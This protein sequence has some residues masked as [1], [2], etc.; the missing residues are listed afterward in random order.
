MEDWHAALEG[1]VAYF[2]S[3]KPRDNELVRVPRFSS[4]PF[5]VAP[6]TTY[7]ELVLPYWLLVVL[8]AFFAAL[9]I[10]PRFSLRNLI[11]AMSLIALLFGLVAIS[12]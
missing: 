1:P 3:S 11:I 12:I 4:R 2:P 5:V 6:G 8:T 9:L 7:Y 10:K